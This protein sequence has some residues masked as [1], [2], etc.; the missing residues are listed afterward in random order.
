LWCWGG[1]SSGQLGIGDRTTQ[2]TPTRVGT[3]TNWNSVAASIYVSVCATRTD[4]T[5][6]CWGDGGDYQ[7]GTGN[8]NSEPTPTQV[9]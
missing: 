9:Q 6:W 8:T 4:H 5:L 2:A 1:N 7:L 3:A